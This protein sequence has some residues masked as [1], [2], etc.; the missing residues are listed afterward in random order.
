MSFHH[1]IS[2]VLIHLV[3]PVAGL[4]GYV[5]LCTRMRSM[6]IPDPPFISYFFLFFNLG[7]WLMIFLTALFWF[8]SGMASIGALYLTFISPFIASIF[9]F[10][11][12]GARSASVFHLRA[13]QITIFYT[14]AVF[15]LDAVW[16]ISL[17]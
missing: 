12:A 1:I 7:G 10:R 5:W 6:N 15:T 3:M 8:W 11:L 13:F 2:F 14:V 4:A 17:K 16:I 9:A